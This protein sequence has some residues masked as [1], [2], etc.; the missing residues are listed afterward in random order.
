MMLI[1]VI[2]EGVETEEEGQTLIGLGCPVAQGF[3]IAPPMA[4]EDISEWISK[5]R[6]FDSW[7]QL[8]QRK[9]SSPMEGALMLVIDHS[10]AA[11]QKGVLSTLNSMENPREE[12]INEH[13]CLPGQWIDNAGKIQFGSL[14]A[15]EE[16]KKLHEHLHHQTQKAFMARDRN[17]A[18]TLENLKIE[19]EEN[20][21]TLRKLLK[22]LS[23]GSG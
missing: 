12:W 6:P 18:Q 8:S 11:F 21:N 3:A 10:L 22:N 5:W 1:N 20:A 4:P 16:F 15:F 14:P 17:D 7:T 9:D 19:L 2:A 13:A 23:S